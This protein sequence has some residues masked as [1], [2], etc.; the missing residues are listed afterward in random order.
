MDLF[1]KQYIP[2]W[3]RKSFKFIVLRLPANTF[4]SKKKNGICP[5]L[6]MPPSKSLSPVFIST[7]QAEGNYPFL[8][9][10]VFWGS[11]FSLAEKGERI[12]ELIKLSNLNVRR[13]W[14]Q[15]LINSTIFTFF[16]SVLL[17]CVV[18][19]KTSINYSKLKTEIW[20][21]KLI[22]FLEFFFLFLVSSE[23]SHVGIDIKKRMSKI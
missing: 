10:S 20:K 19:L 4:V 16:A 6:L 14:S 12:M 11:I 2:P 3:L 8:P 5:F 15:V 22:F 23:Y 7:L 1:L 9:N 13:Y 17:C 18:L 21:L